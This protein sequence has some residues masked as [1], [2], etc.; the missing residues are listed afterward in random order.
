MFRLK[1]QKADTIVITFRGTEVFS[2]DDWCTDFDIS[3]Y[4]LYG[5]IKIHGGFMK[6]LG[7]VKDQG[8]PKN[9]KRNNNQLLAYYSIRDKLKEILG[10]DRDEKTKFM[11]TGHSLGGALAI[12][13]TTILGFH[14]ENDLLKRLEG[15]Y[16]F[17]QPRVGDKELKIFMEELL[18]KYNFKYLRF[19]YS[20]DLIPKLPADDSTFLFKHFGTCLY[21]NSF[22]KGEVNEFLLIH[23]VV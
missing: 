7:L 21:Y 18:H 16:T 17:G 11:L 3:W 10:S 12:L 22:Y 14:E 19:I 8:W 13:F 4:E 6:A 15:V 2:A 23:E 9:I 5:N 20:N 1:T